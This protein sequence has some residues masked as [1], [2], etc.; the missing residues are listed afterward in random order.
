MAQVRIDGVLDA[1]DVAYRRRFLLEKYPQ[2]GD[3][4]DFG[5][6]A[7]PEKKP[8]PEADIR[9]SLAD[10]IAEAGGPTISG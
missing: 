3:G 10:E 1:A 4:E 6:I 2:L 9:I 8:A 5:S 7:E